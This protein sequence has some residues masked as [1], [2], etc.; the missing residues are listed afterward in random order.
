MVDRHAYVL[1]VAFVALAGLYLASTSRAVTEGMAAARRTAEAPHDAPV[2]VRVDD[3]LADTVLGE[4]RW[5][6]PGWP[7][8]TT[9]YAPAGRADHVRVGA[10]S[11]NLSIASVFHDVRGARQSAGGVWLDGE[12]RLRCGTVDENGTPSALGSDE[13]L[14]RRSA[15]RR[16]IQFRCRS[17]TGLGWVNPDS[18]S[19]TSSSSELRTVASPQ[20]EPQVSMAYI[21]PPDAAA[22]RAARLTQHRLLRLDRA[23][24][25]AAVA[26]GWT[27]LLSLVAFGLEAL[28]D[29]PPTR[30]DPRMTPPYRTEAPPPQPTLKRSGF[31]ARLAGLS[32]TVALL[33]ALASLGWVTVERLR[34][35]EP[36]PQPSSAT[37]P[38]PDF[39]RTLTPL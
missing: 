19:S 11:G 22:R 29:R 27:A 17:A 18:W 25:T 39:P 33:G 28:R 16:L 14:F 4:Q 26:L 10:A 35:K 38:L 12:S 21:P 32:S 6:F 15:D 23:T 34:A 1:L 31:W 24:R 13:L 30:D 7:D 5:L 36:T 20:L 9:G 37:D 2:W 8:E 3:T